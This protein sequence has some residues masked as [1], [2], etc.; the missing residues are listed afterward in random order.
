MCVL[1]DAALTWSEQCQEPR[2]QKLCSGL[3]RPLCSD[4]V[5]DSQVIPCFTAFRNDGEKDGAWGHCQTVSWKCSHIHFSTLVS[6]QSFLAPGCVDVWEFSSAAA[7]RIP[8]GLVVSKSPQMTLVGSIAV[9]MVSQ[10]LGSSQLEVSEHGCMRVNTRTS[11]QSHQ[12]K[13]KPE[14]NP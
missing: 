11:G 12:L 4:A 3:K 9:V 2:A 6:L 8:A 7:E 13:C 10:G 5:W 1:L 14:T